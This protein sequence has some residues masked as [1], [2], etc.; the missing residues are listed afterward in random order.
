M[1][2]SMFSD[3]K[4]EANQHKNRKIMSLSLSTILK[5]RGSQGGDFWCCPPTNPI[6]IPVPWLSAYHSER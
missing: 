1:R 6:F 5:C 4:V 2:A 3:C